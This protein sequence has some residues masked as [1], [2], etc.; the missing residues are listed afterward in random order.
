MQRL[1]YRSL[2]ASVI[3]LLPFCTNA[4]AEM[5]NCTAITYVPY[6]IT[7]PGN[8]CL[9]DNISTAVTSGYVITVS[10]SDVVLD[11]NGF[12][13]DGSSA[14]PSTLARGIFTTSAAARVVIRNGRV[15]GFAYGTSLN[16][17]G[18]E[19][20]DMVF[21]S[22]L[23][24]GIHVFGNYAVIAHNKILNTGKTG[25][26]NST[27]TAIEIGDGNLV[28]DNLIYGLATNGLTSSQEQGIKAGSM[29]T[30]RDNVIIDDAKPSAAI[31]YGIFATKSNMLGNTVSNF[32]YGI[33]TYGGVYTM[34][35]MSMCTTNYTY[36]P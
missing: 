8:Y 16:G 6:S 25:G 22:N 20:R 2:F 23:Y 30:I 34:N 4:H 19:V 13:L 35:L 26:P 9:T 14:G 15:Y 27:T 21:E 32:T 28:D 29:N 17:P 11:F 36:S 5:A 31:S 7:A 1:S 18:A 24:K 10:A 3:A 12:T 33:F